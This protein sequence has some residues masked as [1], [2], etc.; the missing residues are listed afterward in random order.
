MAHSSIVTRHQLGTASQEA[1]D[2]GAVFQETELLAAGDKILLRISPEV[3]RRL[4]RAPSK[5]MRTATATT[6]KILQALAVTAAAVENLR[7]KIAMIL[8][9]RYQRPRKALVEMAVPGGQRRARAPK[10][11]G[12]PFVADTRRVQP[13]L[14]AH[15]DYVNCPVEPGSIQGSHWPISLTR[16]CM[17]QNTRERPIIQLVK[18]SNNGHRRDVL[19]SLQSI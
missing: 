4:Y 18:Y 10:F 9:K 17:V 2:P 19:R 12:C 8:S 14:S 3:Q 6:A 13:L 11:G 5:A 15:N 16:K 1:S 7:R